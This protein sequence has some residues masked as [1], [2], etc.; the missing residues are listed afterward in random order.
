ME[1]MLDSTELIDRSLNGWMDLEPGYT[2]LISPEVLA[3]ITTKTKSNLTLLQATT[4]DD[5]TGIRWINSD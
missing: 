4:Y 3:D 1:K 2:N 5:P